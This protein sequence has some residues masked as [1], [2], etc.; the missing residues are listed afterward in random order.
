M[1]LNM[2]GSGGAPVDYDL[3]TA[4]SDNVT[5]G[6]TFIGRGS[7]ESQ[8]GALKNQENKGDSP[9]LSKSSPS[10]PLHDA[11]AAI[12]TTDTEGRIK[13]AMSPAKGKWPGN[14]K[15]YIGYPCAS[16]GIVPDAIANKRQVAGVIGTYGSDGDFS[17]DDLKEGMVGYGANGRIIGT[18]KDYGNVKKVL[19]A[20]E[21]YILPKG[22][23]DGG[24]VS[25][26]TLASQTPGS[27][28]S[29]DMRSGKAAWVGGKQIKGSLVSRGQYQYASGLG[30]GTE[31]GVEYFAFNGAPEG[32]Y[33]SKGADWAPELRM[34]KSVLRSELGIY[35]SRIKRGESIAGVNGNVDYIE[36]IWQE[37]FNGDIRYSSTGSNWPVN[38]GTII[39]YADRNKYDSIILCVIT[40]LDNPDRENRWY[41]TL[42]PTQLVYLIIFD[43]YFTTNGVLI[44]S[45]DSNG[46]IRYQSARVSTSRTIKTYIELACGYTGYITSLK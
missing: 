39:G 31:N 1:R 20:G 2:V 23:F 33:E 26:A 18:R 34:K 17:A 37:L 44:L 45:W 28:G 40:E 38:G 22:M 6:L 32:I 19:N 8:R 41:I 21:K 42:G 25:A 10:I 43:Y 12:A 9:G 36:T 30:T 14:R 24:E 7:D 11:E 46:N 27:A 4:D 3:L 35:E 15:A 16:L 5:E 13:I 29:S